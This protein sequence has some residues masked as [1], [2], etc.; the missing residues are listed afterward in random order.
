M[1]GP[2][3]DLLPFALSVK[4]EMTAGELIVGVGTGAL[5][6]FTAWLAARTSREVK[7]TERGLGLTR[8]SIEALDRPFVVVTPNEHHQAVAFRDVETETGP[9]TRFV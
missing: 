6:A 2:W 3:H 9:R 7:L 4:G 8:E 1:Y 5:A